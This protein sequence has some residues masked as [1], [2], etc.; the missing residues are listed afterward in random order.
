MNA[1]NSALHDVSSFIADKI[2]QA[3]NNAAFFMDNCYRKAR[4]LY[5]YG[6][7]DPVAK[8][9]RIAEECNRK[10]EDRKRNN[11]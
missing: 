7:T 6:S 1:L 4:Y 2:N 9:L 3:A 11:L 5:L 10:S 8:L